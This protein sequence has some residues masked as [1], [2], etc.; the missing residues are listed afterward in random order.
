MG[1]IRLSCGC[2]SCDPGSIHWRIIINPLKTWTVA[3]AVGVHFVLVR[4]EI[5]FLL[6]FEIAHFFC[7]HP[8]YIKCSQILR[9]RA[10]G[11][12]IPGKY[13][14]YSFL[15]QVRDSAVSWDTATSRKVGGS[16]PNGVIGIFHW[17]NPS[18]HTMVLGLTQP[19]TELSTRSIYWG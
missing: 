1:R 3:A 5:H 6:I 2:V 16:F 9:Q 12:V 18:G 19:L 15:L 11:I 17:H 14:W 8:V 4:W 10:P 13:S 7:K